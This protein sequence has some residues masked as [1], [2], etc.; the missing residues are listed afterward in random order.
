MAAGRERERERG[1]GGSGIQ[2]I[3]Y[4]NEE[5]YPGRQECRNGPRSSGTSVRPLGS[6]VSSMV[7]GP[8][9]Q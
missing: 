5:H 1:G 6:P 3:H 8:A 2:N 7:Q 9:R 4:D